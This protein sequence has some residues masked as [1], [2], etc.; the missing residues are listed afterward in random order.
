MVPP[1]T[2]LPRLVKVAGIRVTF[3]LPG[4]ACGCKKVR[5]VLCLQGSGKMFEKA[6]QNK[7]EKD[8]TIMLP[9]YS[10]DSGPPASLGFIVPLHFFSTELQTVEPKNTEQC[11]EGKLNRRQ[12]Q[13]VTSEKNGQNRTVAL[14]ITHTMLHII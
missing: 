7:A 9:I 1:A 3:L 2:L 14:S 8:G 4:P 12:Q 13:S 5:P 10:N 6:V 11:G